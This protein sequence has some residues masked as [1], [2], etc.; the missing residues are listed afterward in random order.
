MRKIAFFDLDGTITS[1]IDGEIPQ[2]TIDSIKKAREKGNLMYVNTGRSFNNIDQ[3]FH[4]IGWDGYV[5]GCGTHIICEGR[6]ILYKTLPRNIIE[7][8]VNS[9]REC[10]MDLLFESKTCIYF[11]MFRPLSHPEAIEIY[12]GLL[13]TDCNMNVDLASPDF[14]A[15][16]FCVWLTKDSDLEKF[17]K[18][19]DKYFQC[20][21]RYDTFKEFVPFGF[22][23]ATGIQTVLDFYKIP[24]ENSYAFGD[25]NNDLPMLTYVPNSIAMGNSVPESIFELVSYKT[26]KASE[27]G[28][29]QALKHFRFI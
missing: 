26:A 14:A 25:S 8:I 22:S 20:I 16:K 24:I 17:R 28:I 5:C 1:E 13:K 27:H 15:D 4:N 10:K 29:E 3:R 11:D 21:N 12:N 6:E 7:E 9:A 19:S 23:K 2:S 18:V